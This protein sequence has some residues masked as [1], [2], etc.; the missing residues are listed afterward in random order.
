LL[1]EYQIFLKTN[2]A[3]LGKFMQSL[4]TSYI[5]LNPVKLKS[6]ESKSPADFKKLLRIASHL[7]VGINGISSNTKRCDEKLLTNKAFR[8]QLQEI[9]GLLE[10]FRQRKRGGNQ[11]SQ[12]HRTCLHK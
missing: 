3:N 9:D 8:K 12:L 5:H 6:L 4:I 2:H 10:F 11:N 7:G 1:A